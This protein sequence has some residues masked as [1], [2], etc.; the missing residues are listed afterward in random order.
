MGQVA[1]AGSNFVIIFALIIADILQRNRANQPSKSA[2]NNTSL[3]VP[4]PSCLNGIQLCA[5]ACA[6]IVFQRPA[7]MVSNPAVVDSNSSSVSPLEAVM[8]QQLANVNPKF[9][10]ALALAQYGN[11][12]LVWCVIDMLV[13]QEEPST[14][15]G[16]ES[17]HQPKQQ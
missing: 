1:A 14:A 10:E 9:S 5:C 15:I 7:V 13:L 3:Q 16:T 17:A 6:G 4:F 11:C 2:R 8:M 12:S